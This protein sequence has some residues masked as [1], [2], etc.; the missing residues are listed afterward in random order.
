MVGKYNTY[1][2]F[3]LFLCFQGEEIHYLKE[4]IVMLIFLLAHHSVYAKDY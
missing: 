4:K 3:I 1:F 2:K